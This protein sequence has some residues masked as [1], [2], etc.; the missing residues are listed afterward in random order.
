MVTIAEK[1]DL[2]EP[3]PLTDQVYL[4]CTQRESATIQSSVKIKSDFFAE[5]TTTET[6]AKSKIKDLENRKVLS[7]SYNM[8]GNAEK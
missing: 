1:I 7:W 8:K 2:E 6:E 5:I 3:T 4:G